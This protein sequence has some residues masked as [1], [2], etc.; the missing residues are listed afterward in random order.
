[1][2]HPNSRPNARSS[3]ATQDSSTQDSSDQNPWS[4]PSWIAAVGFLTMIV[5]AGLLVIVLA[6]RHSDGTAAIWPRVTAQPSRAPRANPGT[7]CNLPAPNMTAG[8]STQ[9]SPA[10]ARWLYEG[11][12]AY[13][14]STLYGPGRTAREG[15]RYCYQHSAGGALY[16]A[17]NTIALPLPSDRSNAAYAK[18][19]I[20]TGPYHDQ[21]LNAGSANVPDPSLRMQITGF[22]ILEYDKTTATV[23]LAVHAT[24]IDESLQLSLVFDLV[25]QRG[26]WRY[27]TRVPQPVSVTRASG[28][29]GYTTWGDS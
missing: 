14:V 22:R 29:V 20:A 18:Y 7:S 26:D 28:L 16:M 2:H 11:A 19:V 4:R 1:M 12:S 24:T 5:I 17:A 15:Y 27:S 13:P 6:P 9:V 25:W 21:Q 3:S 23:D 10:G 8:E